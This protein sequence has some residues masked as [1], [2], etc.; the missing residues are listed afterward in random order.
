MA[1]RTVKEEENSLT[2]K[3]KQAFE[4]FSINQTLSSV[5]PF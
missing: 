5:T 3:I 1:P 2:E 4:L